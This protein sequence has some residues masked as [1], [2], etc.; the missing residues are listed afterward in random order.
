LR[1]RFLLSNIIK[2]VSQRFLIILIENVA[3]TFFINNL[4]KKTFFAN[5][6]NCFNKKRCENVLCQK[7]DKKTFSQR[8]FDKCCETVFIKKN[9]TFSHIFLITL[10]K[11]LRKRFYK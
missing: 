4:I 8:F 10:I 2:N 6:F 3:K 5:V 9:K 1:K 11:M 7:F